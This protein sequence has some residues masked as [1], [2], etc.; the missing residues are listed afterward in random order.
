MKSFIQIVLAFA[1][2]GFAVFAAADKGKPVYMS[3]AGYGHDLSMDSNE[4][5]F[6]ANL[7]QAD[8]N[9]TFGRSTI[10]ITVEFEPDQ[11]L[12]GNCPEK[13][14]YAFDVVPENYWA[15]VT[16]FPDHSQLF[17]V[18]NEGWLC[19]TEDMREWE[20][21]SNGFY[22]GG[23]GRFADA[24]GTWVSTYE[25]E[26]LDSVTGFRSIT[27]DVTGVLYKD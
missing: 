23:S 16:T 11:D 4:D 14:Y 10:A 19:M 12:L 24:G 18:F 7:T 6:A 20:G 17:G 15:F 27:G 5:G 2:L 3:Y 22:Y 13:Y 9:G 1:M 26:N 8:G 21:Q 25:G